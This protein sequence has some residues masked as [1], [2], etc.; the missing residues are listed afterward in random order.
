LRYR[1]V[2]V[3]LARFMAVTMIVVFK[4]FE[5]VTD[6]EE[7]VSVETDVHESRLHTGKDA[8]DFAFVDASDE[9]EFLFALDVDFD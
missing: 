9:G 8:C 5:D 6:I 7:G 1:G 2:T 4:I 3:S